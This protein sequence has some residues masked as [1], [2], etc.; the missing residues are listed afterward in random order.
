[1]TY[2]Y[3]FPSDIAELVRRPMSKV[4][5]HLKDVKI[6]YAWGGTLAITMRRLPYLT[7]LSPTILSASGY[8][9]HGVGMATFSGKLLAD[10]IAGEAEGFDT[11]ARIPTLPFPGG[12]TFRSPVLMLAMTWFALRDRLGV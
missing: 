11:M 1:E 8:S 10:A 12:T 3:R 9:G 6:D 2:R 4:F 5:P 7:R